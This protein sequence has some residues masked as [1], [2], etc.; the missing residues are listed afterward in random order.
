MSEIYEQAEKEIKEVQARRAF[1][2][3]GGPL[4][5]TGL[6]FGPSSKVPPEQYRDCVLCG[7]SPHFIHIK[8]AGEYEGR[9]STLKLTCRFCGT[10]KTYGLGAFIGQA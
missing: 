1:L 6:A 5:P 9:P 3:N 10:Q 2:G 7:H 8:E 4:T